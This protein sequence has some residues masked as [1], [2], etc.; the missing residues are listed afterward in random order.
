VRGGTA[1]RSRRSRA[2]VAVTL[3]VM[4]ACSGSSADSAPGV[5][6]LRRVSASQYEQ[7][8]TDL[9]GPGIEI[10]GRFEPDVRRDGLLALGSSALSVTASGF[11]QYYA[12]AASVADQALAEQRRTTVVPCQPTDAKTADAACAAAFVEKYGRL[13]FRRRLARDEVEARVALAAEAAARTESFYEGLE[14]ALVSL[15]I[16]SNYLFRVERSELDPSGDLRLDAFTKA[17]RLSYLL[18]NTTPDDE[19]LQAAETGALHD[20]AELRRQVQ[21]MLAAPRLEAGLR[22]FFRDVLHFDLLNEI[23]KDAQLYPKYSSVVA[24]SAEEETLRTIVDHLLV[25]DADYRE[26]FTTRETHV[27][28]T[29]AAAYGTPYVFDEEWSH[30]TFDEAEGRAGILSRIAFLALFSHPGDSSP[31]KRGVAILEMLKCEPTP[32]PPANVDF[33]I[34]N[35]VSNPSLPTRRARLLA[36]STEESCSGCHLKSDPLGLA[37]EHFD[38]MGQ[39]RRTENGASIDVNVELGGRVYTGAAGLG[40]ALHDDP[41]VTRCL[42]KQLYGYGAGRPA[43]PSVESFIAHLHDVLAR[44][45]HRV[46]TLLEHLATSPEFFRVPEPQQSAAERIAA[47]AV[48]SRAPL[49]EL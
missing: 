41:S 2:L 32:E 6:A 17:A 38:G 24:R 12:I 36:H 30:H 28:R 20:D 34:V 35:D 14:L 3:M 11:E 47:S 29:L 9:F 46:K 4:S 1:S 19:L 18:W 26:L 25:R 49:G 8:V 33:S 45:G 37:L 42:V 48:R 23:T 15:M 40:A 44:N 43:D 31:T 27:D 13:L 16:S 39:I 7:I 10:T 22:A 5:V 21:R